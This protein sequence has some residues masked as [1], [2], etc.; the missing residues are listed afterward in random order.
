[1]AEPETAYMCHR[2]K[3]EKKQTYEQ[4]LAQQSVRRIVGRNILDKSEPAVHAYWGPL[5]DNAEGIEFETDISPTGHLEPGG[6]VKWHSRRQDVERFT[7]NG[8]DHAK[9]RIRITKIRYQG[10]LHWP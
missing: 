1:M 7:R 3:A 2:R 8:T 6:Y 5:P 10:T 4:A 9:I